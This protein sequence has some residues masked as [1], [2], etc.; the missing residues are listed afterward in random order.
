MTQLFT[1]VS[2]LSALP[3]SM[4]GLC[5]MTQLFTVCPFAQMVSSVWLISGVR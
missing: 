5:Q 4:G 2:L 3:H 1:A